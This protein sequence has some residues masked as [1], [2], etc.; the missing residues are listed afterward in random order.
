MYVSERERKREGRK[1]GGREEKREEKGG[2]KGRWVSLTQGLG[3]IPS[4]WGGLVA[5]GAVTLCPQSGGREEGLY[6]VSLFTNIQ[7]I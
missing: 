5:E 1:E 6:H 3:L 2:K 7:S 4:W